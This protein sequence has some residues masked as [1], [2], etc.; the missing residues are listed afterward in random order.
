MRLAL[1]YA[2]AG[3]LCCLL[4]GIA[5]GIAPG[6]TP[7]I[8]PDTAALQPFALSQIR[9]HDSPFANA[10]LTNQQYL[11]AFDADRLLAPFLREAGLPPA[12]P[13]YPNWES[14]GLD[15][16]IGGHYLSALS[17]A[18]AAG[19]DAE[20][21]RRLDYML[22]QLSL[23]QQK[24]ADGYIGGVPGS[25]ALWQQIRQGWITADLFSLN[26]AWVPWYNLHKTFAGLRDAW[27]LA[28]REP[29]KQMLLQYGQW[30]KQLSANLSEQ[31]IQQMLI[32]EHGGINEVLVDLAEISGDASYL[33]L[34]Q[35]Y[36]QQSLLKPL[37]AGEDA[38]T[39]LHANTQIPKVIGFWR[40]GA[41]AALPD[42]QQAAAFF[43]HTVTEQR[44]TV[45]GGNSV[46]E[47]F[48]ARD[49]FISM[50]TDVEGPET[51]NT[52]NMLK[53]ARLLFLHSGD[54]RYLAYY[55]RA[56]YNH[57]LSSQHPKH[58]GL[59]YFTPMR[60]GH[61]RKYSSHDDSMWCCVGSG[62]ENHSKYG[63][64]IY[65][66]AG[67]ELLVNLFIPSTLT[68]PEQ[69][70]Q[71]SLLSRF[72][73]QPDV[74]LQLQQTA[75][76][77]QTLSIRQPDWLA[78]PL[79][80]ALNG[81]P[82]A[83]VSSRPGYLSITR[84]FK[85][86]DEISFTLDAALQLEQLPD[87]SAHY[88]VLYGPVAL[89]QALPPLRGEQLQF[90]ADDSR[91]GHIAAGPLCPQGAAPVIVG[92]PQQFLQGLSRLPGELAFAINQGM[93]AGVPE[94][95]QL[96]ASAGINA[97]LIPFF[98]LH[99]SR[100]QLYL[101]QVSQQQ[102]PKW[103]AGNAARAAAEARLA[104]Q[105]LDQLSPGQQ[106]PEVEHQYQGE[107]S[108]AGVNN[109][110]HWRDSRSWFSYR[111]RDPALQARSV[112]LEYFAADAGRQF[113]IYF[114]DMLLAEVSLP[115]RSDN[116]FYSVQY[117]LTAE[118]LAAS[119]DGSHLLKFVAKPGS[120]AGGIYDIR[121]LRD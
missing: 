69:Q 107:H 62:I 70:L 5:L 45:I 12:A 52:Y 92:E 30:L 96:P 20:L 51:C 25:K 67:S 91:M 120:V 99:D 106:Q 101:P 18:V 56:S 71:L 94:Y 24:H 85:P 78:T 86:G 9:L 84:Q 105:T 93:S 60:S 87:N 104:A 61:Y 119:L 111:L 114:N 31:Q 97:R 63:E 21:G 2:V 82:V 49:D 77:P 16:H 116:G 65:S 98:R 109:G 35:R 6:K 66:R 50:L 39:G 102:Y 19:G 28:G 76:Q 64:L 121:L 27:L 83:A 54:T 90:I 26:Q 8:A 32:S 115:E 47:H 37:L 100:Y 58:G 33:S 110:R 118:Q 43:F 57:I 38:L 117:P 53:L 88:A 22:A 75:N 23:V 14:T 74:R 72:P 36:S 46:R 7:G 108:S 81:K 48:H 89:A 79:Q 10:Q 15:G 3:V 42:W 68:W 11:L 95:W 40:L 17:L 29:A 112:Q 1:R 55:E 113:S 59:V 103:Q 80:L 13:P 41:A 4:P 44:S 34:A 73:D